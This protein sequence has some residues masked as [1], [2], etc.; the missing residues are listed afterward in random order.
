MFRFRCEEILNL[1]VKSSVTEMNILVTS[2]CDSPSHMWNVLLVTSL[3]D[4]FYYFQI[5]LKPNILLERAKDKLS[6]SLSSEQVANQ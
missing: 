6:S 4:F 5:S 1:G 3:D 2:I